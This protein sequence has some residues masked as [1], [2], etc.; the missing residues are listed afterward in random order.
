MERLR[1]R[2]IVASRR[3]FD[4]RRDHRSTGQRVRD[5]QRALDALLE[6]LEDGTSAGREAVEH[7]REL[8]TRIF[9]KEQELI[10]QQRL[11]A[12]LRAAGDTGWKYGELTAK[13]KR[14]PS[15]KK[16]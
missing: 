3:L 1:E 14:R 4:A 5:A 2:L 16:G 12:A 8:S 15:P 10:S 6:E 13:R 11:L 7:L 9:T